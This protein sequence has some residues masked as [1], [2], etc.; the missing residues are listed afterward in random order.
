MESYL[1]D[2]EKIP[3]LSAEEELTLLVKAREKNDEKA[4]EKLTLSNLRF[5][6]KIAKQYSGQGMELEDLIS[7]GNIGLMI[8]IDRFDTTRGVRLISYAVWWIRQRMLQSLSS[9]MHAVKVPPNRINERVKYN[10]LSKE[11][12]Q[13]LGRDPTR[14]EILERYED[15]IEPVDISYVPLDKQV[16][17]DNTASILDLI[18]DTSIEPP[19]R[20]AII[21]AL[22]KDLDEVLE[23]C[24]DRE[25]E[26]IYLYHG[27]DELRSFTLEEIG[28]FIGLTR[29][30]VRQIK[31]KVLTKISKTRKGKSLKPYLEEF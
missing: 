29:E 1:K 20:K 6:V 23:G 5:V 21:D 18:E 31:K 19:Y 3:L 17:D 13:E 27:I 12:G 15:I 14:E 9:E 26:I 30:R 22:R 7:E 2:I 25:K 24:T 11:L 16:S 28:S 4:R 10:K 8:A